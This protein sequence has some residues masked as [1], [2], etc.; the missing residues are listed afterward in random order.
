M[1]GAA[2]ASAIATIAPIT[3]CPSASSPWALRRALLQS[4]SAAGRF[5]ILLRALLGFL[6]A[7]TS[8]RP[9]ISLLPPRRAFSSR[10]A[11]GRA[12]LGLGAQFRFPLRLF[13]QLVPGFRFGFRLGAGIGF[14]LLVLW[15]RAFRELGPGLP[16]SPSRSPRAAPSCRGFSWP[17]PPASASASAR[18]L[19]SAACRAAASSSRFLY[20]A[21]LAASWA[22]SLAFSSASFC[23]TSAS[24]LAASSAS[25]FSCSACALALAPV[26]PRATPRS[27]ADLA[28]HERRVIPSGNCCT[29][30]LSL[31]AVAV[32]DRAPE[33]ELPLPVPWRWSLWSI[34]PWPW[35][36]A[37][38][39]FGDVV[40][41][42]IEPRPFVGLRLRP[43]FPL[44]P[45]LSAGADFL[46]GLVASSTLLDGALFTTASKSGDIVLFDRRGQRRVRP[47]RSSSRWFRR[48]SV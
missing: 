10:F 46:G 22:S 19:A 15:P 32:L 12:S 26:S 6:L 40:D 21:S 39:R 36:F 35:P 8:A 43:I 5:G 31:G 18:A 9:S 38:L 13:F 48:P 1:P 47:G 29:S 24:R 44:A 27:L 28:L 11:P 41:V 25:F 4:A 3:V 2:A 20:S 23:L 30:S 16:S 33:L 17:R 37:Q 14:A 42:T 7:L 45:R 34:P